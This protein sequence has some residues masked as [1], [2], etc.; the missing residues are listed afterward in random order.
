MRT[1]RM[2]LATAAASAAL[3]LG[4]PGAHAAD[5][6]TDH[7]SSVS[8]EDGAWSGKKDHGKEGHG[9]AEH[10]KGE[11]DGPHG[12]MHTGGGAL[13]EG[14]GAGAHGSGPRGG[15]KEESGGWSGEHERPSGGMHTGGGALAGPSVTATGLGV[16]TL[17][18]AG[19][20]ALRRRTATEAA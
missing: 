17:A 3:A 14:G 9:K 2:I 1:A 7:G 5:G 18:G 13:T 16:L 4:A 12:G 10:G 19:L 20:C 8:K 6:D 15:G 11:H